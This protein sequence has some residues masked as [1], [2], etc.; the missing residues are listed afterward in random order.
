MPTVLR[1]GGFTI[2]IYLPDREHGPA[3]VHVFKQ[4]G[5]LIVW[6]RPNGVE[7]RDSIGLSRADERTALAIVIDHA[8]LLRS[9]WREYHD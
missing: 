9:K 3:H 8:D 4:G 1:A 7:V 2:K 5:E 6:L